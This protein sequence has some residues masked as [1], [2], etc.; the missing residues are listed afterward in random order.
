LGDEDDQSTI[1]YFACVIVNLSSE[2]RPWNTLR[3]YIGKK[4][5]KK[6]KTAKLAKKI[7]TF[8]QKKLITIPEVMNKILEKRAYIVTHEDQS[9]IPKEHDVIH[10]TTFLP[11]LFLPKIPKQQNVSDT[12]DDSLQR[13]IKTGSIKN[14]KKEKKKTHKN[15]NK[16]DQDILQSF[17]NIL[18]QV[19]V[20]SPVRSFHSSRR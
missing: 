6:E 3:K 10:W 7:N 1:H 11:P 18:N 2:T 20:P 15:R 4:G 17:L 8:I 9:N 14:K 16:T 13:D 5:H 19:S 12:F